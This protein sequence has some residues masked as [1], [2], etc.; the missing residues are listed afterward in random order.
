MTHTLLDIEVLI[1]YH[2]IPAPHPR[3]DAPGVKA[4]I[5]KWFNLGCIERSGDGYWTATERGK[6][7][8]EMLKATP[9]PVQLWIDPRTQ[10][11]DTL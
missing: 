10:N 3:Y 5:S 2:C 7:F 8:L 1:H 4:S 9:L 11:S 6:A